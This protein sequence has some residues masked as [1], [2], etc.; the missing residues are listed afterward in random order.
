[1]SADEI[2]A[3]MAG[4]DE[5]AADLAALVELEAILRAAS[6]SV[7]TALAEREIREERIAVLADRA[8]RRTHAQ[9]RAD[10]FGY[11]RFVPNEEDLI[12]ARQ[13]F[14]C[15]AAES[16]EVVGSIAA[17]SSLAVIVA[18]YIDER[19]NVMEAASLSIADVPGAAAALASAAS[20][21]FRSR[22]ADC[23]HDLSGA[24]RESAAIKRAEHVRADACVSERR[25][26]MPL[27]T[28]RRGVGSSSPLAPRVDPSREVVANGK[29]RDAARSRRRLARTR[30]L[31]T[32]ERALSACAR[33][34]RDLADLNQFLLEIE[35][36]SRR[37]SITVAPA[38][39][40]EDISTT[41]GSVGIDC[42]VGID[43]DH[44][45]QEHRRCATI[46]VPTEHRRCDSHHASRVYLCF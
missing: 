18:E 22:D 17:G 8:A 11:G 1:M 12:S 7:H 4:Y 43:D 44:R 42:S 34:L 21:P 37:R 35:K 25:R 10:C 41:T 27:D 2:F 3:V 29:T 39:F 40:S 26:A 6:I 9:V 16:C 46:A 38:H 5:P 20:A 23:K 14:L 19:A 32:S 36:A 31:E 15:C 45:M 33:D 13:S 24:D 30:A 28:G